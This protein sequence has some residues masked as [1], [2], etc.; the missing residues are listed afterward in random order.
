MM[1]MMMMMVVVVVVVVVVVTRFYLE[2]F[3]VPKICDARGMT[4]DFYLCMCSFM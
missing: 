3:A 1:M 4:T 2:M